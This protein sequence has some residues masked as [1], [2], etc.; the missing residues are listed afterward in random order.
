MTYV[1]EELP[2]PPEELRK[3]FD[4]L[5][6]DTL[7]MVRESEKLAER[8]KELT[9][10]IN[11]ILRDKMPK[12]MSDMHLSDFTTDTGFKVEVKDHIAASIPKE[13]EKASKAFAWLT[14]HGHGDLIK[15]KVIVTFGREEDEKA[16][17][18]AVA[19]AERYPEAVDNKKEVHHMT[20]SAFV[21]DQLQ[22]E[23]APVDFPLDLFNVIRF[24]QAE[25]KPVAKGK[26]K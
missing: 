9:E 8:Q 12:L 6:E 7:A 22:A 10:E 13:S 21:R 15:N 23:E 2:V 3:T 5:V 18:L 16:T 4:K 26:R 1:L 19:L 25:I 20:L 17:E 11:K 24:D 14:E